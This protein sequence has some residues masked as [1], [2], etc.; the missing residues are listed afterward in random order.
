MESQEAE[1]G[2]SR[3]NVPACLPR[4]HSL[5]QATQLKLTRR[6]SHRAIWKELGQ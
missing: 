1:L 6:F 5:G 3:G 2:A 4:L